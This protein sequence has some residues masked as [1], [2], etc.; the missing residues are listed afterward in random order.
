MK[1]ILEKKESEELFHGALC[2]I[3]LGHYG[4]SLD[5]ND[6]DGDAV[7]EQ[8]KKD[9]PDNTICREDVWMGILKNGGK[10]KFID[11]E[12]DGAYTKEITIKDVH[13]KVQKTPI[14]HL[15]DA[16]EER[17]DAI[18]DDCILQTVIWDDII[19]G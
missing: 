1:I 9:T 3:Q 16:I 10:L 2:S 6:K 15:V 14:N 19:F 12:G 7:R 13:E 8:W 18:S 17:G 4:V 11:E 5:Y